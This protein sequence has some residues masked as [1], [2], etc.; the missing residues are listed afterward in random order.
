MCFYTLCILHFAFCIKN[1]LSKFIA[2]NLYFA[3]SLM[4]FFL[5]TRLSLCCLLGGF[6]IRAITNRVIKFDLYNICHQI[7]SCRFPEY[8]IGF[9][10]K[11]TYRQLNAP[12]K[13]A[14]HLEIS[15]IGFF[16]SRLARNESLCR[17][18]CKQSNHFRL[19]HIFYYLL[20][21]CKIDCSNV[22]DRRDISFMA[23]I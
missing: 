7:D 8:F 12:K 23:L 18:L 5:Y 9:K 14:T 4:I 10:K 13:I 1:I 21:F 3:S 19:L 11:K 15:Q 6:N 2:N 20:K 16:S 17:I 22:C